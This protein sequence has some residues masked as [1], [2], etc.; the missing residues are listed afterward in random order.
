MNEKSHFEKF[1]GVFTRSATYLNLVYLYLTFPLGIAY[2]V[3]LV[4]G[5]GLGIFLSIVWIGLLVL[6]LVF[7]ISWGLAAFERM[8]AM[9]MLRV[10]IP[11]MQPRQD[12]AA[13]W[14]PRLKAYFV[15]PVTWKGMLYLFLK[16]PLGVLNFT[17]ATTILT[18]SFALLVTPLALVIPGW[19]IHPGSGYLSLD[20]F[21][22]QVLL[23]PPDP[24]VVAGLS[25]L[26][27]IFALPA[28][29]HLLNWMAGWQGKLAQVMLGRKDL[30]AD[31][32]SRG[33][34]GQ[35]AV[36]MPAGEGPALANL[37]DPN[38]SEWKRGLE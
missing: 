11:P 3:F 8:L 24:Y 6:G 35:E 38:S 33:M 26:V 5:W 12:P 9:G 13:S 10:K 25:F 31:D 18:T 30:M 23:T 22:R 34:V 4:T 16:F 2:L 37:E 36:Q 29:F 21:S 7:A 20:I 27:G 17:V 19:T 14:W 28:S 1:Y 32:S 15:N